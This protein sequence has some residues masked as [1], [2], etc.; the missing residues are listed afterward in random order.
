M[1]EQS[2]TARLSESK[3]AGVFTECFRLIVTRQVV[4]SG[5][6][7]QAARSNVFLRPEVESKSW[8]PREKLVPWVVRSL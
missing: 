8:L 3:S 5:S 2:F 6:F 7:P 4:K 1:R